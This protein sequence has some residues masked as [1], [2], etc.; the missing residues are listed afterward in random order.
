MDWQ[1]GKDYKDGHLPDLRKNRFQISL[2][3]TE[4]L[5]PGR[6]TEKFEPPFGGGWVGLIFIKIVQAT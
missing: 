4:V 3:D 5:N 6:A 1:A 2:S